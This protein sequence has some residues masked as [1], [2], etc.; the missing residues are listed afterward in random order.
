MTS[1]LYVLA[2]SFLSLVINGILI[3]IIFSI[4]F[5]NF[6]SFIKTDYIKILPIIGIISIAIGIHGSLHLGLEQAY[7]YNPLYLLFN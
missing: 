6:R 3:F 4:I 7:H 2:P 5:L 1:S